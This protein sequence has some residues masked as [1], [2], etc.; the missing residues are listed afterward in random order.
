LDILHAPG[1]WSGQREVR[2]SKDLIPGL[3]LEVQ[4]LAPTR[5]RAR[6]QRDDHFYKGM[7]IHADKRPTP[8]GTETDPPRTEG[9]L[10]AVRLEGVSHGLRLRPDHVGQ[11]IIEHSQSDLRFLGIESISPFVCTSGGNNWAEQLIRTL[12]DQFL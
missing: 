5:G 9:I 10:R 2:I 7:W 6:G 8:R 11:F 4:L 12:K 1:L 3:I